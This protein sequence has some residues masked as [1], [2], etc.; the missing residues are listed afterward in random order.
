MP[1][2]VAVS[3]GNLKSRREI[4]VQPSGTL[5]GPAHDSA[6]LRQSSVGRLRVLLNYLLLPQLAVVIGPNHLLAPAVR[7]GGSPCSS[8]TGARRQITTG[9]ICFLLLSKAVY[10]FMPHRRRHWQSWLHAGGTYDKLTNTL[11]YC[12]CACVYATVCH[13]VHHDGCVSTVQ[14]PAVLQLEV[15]ACVISAASSAILAETTCRCVKRS[16]YGNL[17]ISL[18]CGNFSIYFKILNISF[19]IYNL[20]THH[21][22]LLVPL[23]H[24]RRNRSL[25]LALVSDPL[26]LDPL[27]RPPP[28]SSCPHS[29]SLHLPL[30]LPRHCLSPSELH[31]SCSGPLCS[32]SAVVQWVR[33]EARSSRAAAV[34]NNYHCRHCTA[35]DRQPA[36]QS[37][38]LLPLI[39]LIW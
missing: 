5:R 24:P 17:Q 2:S 1:A 30:H 25:C 31:R 28:S 39:F 4:L 11:S 38:C 8:T 6:Y 23:L 14:V 27:S 13:S 34:G 26:P 21:L 29:T 7:R 20:A 32:S 37:G 18:I 19:Y 16:W 10:Y 3:V 35:M 12:Y 22:R 36:L 9:R 33:A 15:F